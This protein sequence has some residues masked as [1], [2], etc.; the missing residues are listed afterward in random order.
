ML[1][2]RR[3]I[4][5]LVQIGLPFFMSLIYLALRLF[6]I[7]A[8][9]YD[10]VTWPGYNISSPPPALKKSF[11]IG[12]SIPNGSD[13]S[14]DFINNITSY[15]NENAYPDQEIKLQYFSSQSAMVNRILDSSDDNSSEYMGGIY[16][17]T[18]PDNKSISEFKYTLRFKAA[19]NNKNPFAKNGH[20]WL[21]KYVFPKFQV[22]Q[23]RNKDSAVGDNPS[24]YDAGFLLT[25]YAVDR[26][27]ASQFGPEPATV[28]MQKFP[29][30]SYVKDGFIIIIQQFM[31][32]FFVIAFIYTALVI[33]RSIVYEK[34]KRLKVSLP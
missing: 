4:G 2:K 28:L 18:P 11:S 1:Q 16:F 14:K 34:E 8:T 26:A 23:P 9:H 5:T 13:L 19:V 17:S 24:Y 20:Q 3:P 29:F 22:P 6:L 27:I 21:T 31:P 33:V 15:L 30:P 32:N 25:Q 7:D 12:Y 10:A